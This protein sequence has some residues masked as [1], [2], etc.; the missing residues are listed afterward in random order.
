MRQRPHR[1]SCSRSIPPAPAPQRGSLRVRVAWRWRQTVISIIGHQLKRRPGVSYLALAVDHL[2][3]LLIEPSRIHRLKYRS[4]FPVS[5]PLPYRPG[6][7]ENSSVQPS[8]G[9]PVDQSTERVI[10]ESVMFGDCILVQVGLE[11]G[12]G[13]DSTVTQIRSPLFV[14]L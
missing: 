4:A 2:G 9:L 12:L 1:R 7:L 11:I 8:D 14:N 6:G 3:T 13:C 10:G 5:H